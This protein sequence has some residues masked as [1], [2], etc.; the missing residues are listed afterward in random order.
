MC[1]GGAGWGGVGGGHGGLITQ[2]VGRAH[3]CCHH[4]QPTLPHEGVGVKP[5]MCYHESAFFAKQSNL[6]VGGA[7]RLAEVRRVV[8]ENNRVSG[9]KRSTGVEGARR[10]S[11]RGLVLG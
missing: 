4:R 2:Q 1:G 8:R 10:L 11:P 5:H 6:L 3:R 9:A 7:P